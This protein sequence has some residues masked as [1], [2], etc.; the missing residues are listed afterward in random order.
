MGKNVGDPGKRQSCAS[1]ELDW[2]IKFALP[3][4][5]ERLTQCC[6]SVSW[7]ARRICGGSYF[8]GCWGQA[9]CS[10]NRR[11]DTAAVWQRMVAI[12]TEKQGNGTAMVVAVEVHRS[13]VCA[14]HHLGHQAGHSELK[15]ARPTMRTVRKPERLELRP[16]GEAIRATRRDWIAMETEWAVSNC[17]A[18]AQ[19]NINPSVMKR[20]EPLIGGEI[21]TLF[22][23]WILM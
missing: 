12:G 1:P 20:L 9:R 6:H 4:M 13:K 21:F 19:T 14:R 3:H 8:W 7:G 18:G 11:T 17:T 10:T 16:Y 22:V 23:R 15:A 2:R 5:P